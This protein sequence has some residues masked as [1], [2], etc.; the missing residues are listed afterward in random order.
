MFSV[1]NRPGV[2]VD[3]DRWITQVRRVMAERDAYKEQVS[4]LTDIAQTAEGNLAWFHGDHGEDYAR[5]L[6]RRLTYADNAKPATGHGG[7][8]DATSDSRARESAPEFRPA[9][10]GTVDT[11]TTT[12]STTKKSSKMPDP[13]IFEGSEGSIDLENWLIG[14]T[15]ALQANAVVF[16]RLGNFR[17]MFRLF[18]VR[19]SLG[20]NKAEFSDPQIQIG[21]YAGMVG[22][23]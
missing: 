10:E 3:L 14:I 22:H 23:A 1:A 12:G 19:V 16:R 18:L 6:L 13:P 17:E 2:K 20:H 4:H 15:S 8:K 21:L 9:R 7:T 5:R 11:V